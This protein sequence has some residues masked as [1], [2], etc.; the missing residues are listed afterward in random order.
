MAGFVLL[1][2]KGFDA[3]YCNCISTLSRAIHILKTKNI[4]LSDSS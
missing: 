4:R 3:L 2:R 1:C